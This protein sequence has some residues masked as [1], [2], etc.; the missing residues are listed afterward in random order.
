[1]STL[2][3]L[4]R[5]HVPPAIWD[6]FVAAHEDGWWFQTSRW[7]DY[8]VAYAGEDAYDD[9]AAVVS[10]GQIIALTFGVIDRHKRPGCGG[11]PVPAALIR[12]DAAHLLNLTLGG[13][14]GLTLA[15]RPGHPPDDDVQ[16]ADGYRLTERTTTVVDLARSEAAIWQSVRRSYHAI[17]H[18]VERAYGISVHSRVTPAVAATV[19]DAAHALHRTCSGRETRDD[20][21]W[22]MQAEWLADGYGVLA[23]ADRDAQHV[24]FAYA[25]RYKDWAYWM[26]GGSLER[27]VQHALQWALIKALRADGVTQYYEVGWHA[28]PDEPKKDQDIAFFKRGFGAPMRFSWLEEADS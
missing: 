14:P 25:V 9:S 12:P 10:D 19:T 26:S 7:L 20:A 6:A 27:N 17:I 13:A 18:G 4:L 21:T 3:V 2:R 1:M 8:A 24:G 23:L 5:K 15:W 16:F 11:Q 28:R 22:R